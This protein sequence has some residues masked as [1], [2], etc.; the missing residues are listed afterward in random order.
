MAG[1][2]RP[3]KGWGPTSSNGPNFET[4]LRAGPTCK[5]KSRML[6]RRADGNGEA[7]GIRPLLTELVGAPR[8]VAK[9]RTLSL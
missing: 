4:P 8:L 6:T 7:D 1:A 2:G 3:S 9:L 5:A